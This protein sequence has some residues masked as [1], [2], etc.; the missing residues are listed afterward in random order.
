MPLNYL[1]SQVKHQCLDLSPYI[2]TYS[3]I[4]NST[5]HYYS[6]NHSMRD[7]SKIHNCRKISKHILNLLNKLKLMNCKILLLLPFPYRSCIELIHLVMDLEC[8]NTLEEL[9]INV[10]L[11]LR[12]TLMKDFIMLLYLEY[13]YYLANRNSLEIWKLSLNPLLFLKIDQFLGTKHC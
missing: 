3:R 5:I 9:M 6:R 10:N 11:S 8:F 12:T 1:L 4:L 7:C 2:R 13:K